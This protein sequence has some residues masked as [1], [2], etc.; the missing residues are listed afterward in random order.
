M[1]LDLRAV[2]VITKMCNTWLTLS[3]CQSGSA[4]GRVVDSAPH[5]HGCILVSGHGGHSPSQGG[6][7]FKAHISNE[8]KEEVYS[9]FKIIKGKMLDQTYSEEEQSCCLQ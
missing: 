7:G 8:T 4:Q 1:I 2:R 9:A 5:L 3:H 6:E